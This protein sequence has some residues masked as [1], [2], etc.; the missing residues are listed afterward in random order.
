RG[1]IYLGKK[2]YKKAVEF[3]KIGIKISKDNGPAYYDL[4]CAYSLMNDKKKALKSLKLAVE[5]GYAGY[6]HM[7]KDSD[8]DNIRN[9]KTFKDIMN[10]LK[11]TK[12]STQ[13]AQS[14]Q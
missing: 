8:L 4:T 14:D 2:E 6:E 10:K 9:E 13:S 5:K 7:K 11:D 1:Y 3:F 12:L